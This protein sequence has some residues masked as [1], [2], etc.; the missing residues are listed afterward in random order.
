MAYIELISR[1]QI[2]PRVLV[3]DDIVE[4][5]GK[6]KW[7][8]LSGYANTNIRQPDG[9]YKGVRMHRMILSAADDEICDHINRNRLDN[10]RSNL[11]I[12]TFQQNAW[13]RTKVSGYSDYIGVAS[14]QYYGEHPRWVACIVMSGERVELGTYDDQEEAAYIRDQFAMQLQGEYASLNFEYAEE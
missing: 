8:W 4:E 13:N 14:Y 12:A 1:D 6:Y 5:L 7:V 3:D 10:R 2:K 9:T 11:R